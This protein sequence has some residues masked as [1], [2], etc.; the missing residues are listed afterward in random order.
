M[1]KKNA[2][3]SLGGGPSP[4]I[5]A[6]LLGVVRACLDFD[7]IGEVYGALH[8]VEGVLKEELVRLD[9]QDPP[10]LAKLRYTPASGAIGTCRYKLGKGK[11][12]QEDYTRI[13]DVLAAHDVGYFFYIG[14]NDSMDTAFKVSE[15]ARKKGVCLVCAG[16]PKTID[17]D[18]GDEERTLIDHT[19]GFGSAARYWAM[20]M[21][22]AEAENRGM[23][24]SEPV[25]VYQ[26]MGRKAGFIAAAARL[27]DPER[28]MPLQMY[29]AETGQ[30]IETLYAN[31]CRSLKDCGRAIVIVS[32]GFDAGAPLGARDGFGHIEY[33]AG[34]DT[35][36]QSVVSYLNRRGLPVRGNATGQIPGVMQRGT[37]SCRSEVD[38]REAYEVGRHAVK[39]ALRDGTGWMA[40]IL[41]DYTAPH[42]R[43]HYDKALM[44]TIANSARQLP[45]AWIAESGIDVTDDYV[46]YAM[47]LIGDG[48]RTVPITGPGGLPDHARLDL[49]RLAKKLPDY[50]PAN[51]RGRRG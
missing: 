18:L 38:E 36:M 51:F 12:A 25:S 14:G 9:T 10:E 19:P 47:P 8:G 35:A 13:L 26:A 34:D 45:K 42:Y 22:D 11:R 50:V 49:T 37:S 39:I 24:V 43:I 27:A 46:D 4:V 6:S 41:R 23:Y 3:V 30:N 29:F 21:R 20:L 17:N 2:L 7:E 40:T 16:V 33:G 48:L 5:N 44:K 32:E 31:V 28:R 15:L 1:S